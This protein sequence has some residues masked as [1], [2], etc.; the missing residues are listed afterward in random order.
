M[1]IIV[2]KKLASVRQ[3][4][5]DACASTLRSELA[6]AL[7][8][9]CLACASTLRELLAPQCFVSTAKLR[10]AKLRQVLAQDTCARDM[11]SLIHI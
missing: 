3:V 2:L 4:A 11:L 6:R 9:V 8:I 7:F 10:K 1:Y 5:R